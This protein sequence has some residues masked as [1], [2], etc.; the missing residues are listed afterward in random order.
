MYSFKELKNQIEITETTVECPVKNC[1]TKVERQKKEFKRDER[2]LCIKHSIYISPSTYEYVNYQDNLL[3]KD[4]DDIQLLESILKSKRESRISRERS[5][6]ALTWNVFRYLDK[7]NELVEWCSGF[8]KK[9]V[10]YTNIIYWSYC[11]NTNGTYPLLKE[12]RAE[13]GEANSRGSEPDLIIETDKA[14]FF[15]ESKLMAS[16]KTNPS[17]P[18][19]TKKYLTGGSEWFSKVFKSPYS[20]IICN[21]KYELMRFWLLGTW[22]ASKT[23]KE[24]FLVNLVPIFMEEE[25]EANFGKHIIQ[26]E[27]RKFYRLTWENMFSYID[28]KYRTDDEKL[29]S[30]Y[31]LNKTIGYNSNGKLSRALFNQSFTDKKIVIPDTST[32]EEEEELGRLVKELLKK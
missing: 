13:F 27:Q 29:L 28:L 32:P 1:D 9:R 12:A 26:N 5:E 6:D 16:N 3:W 21:S 30:D 19:V 11:K 20:E 8:V 15:I 17:N 24:F 10:S 7:K 25:I 31:L 23:K 2:F 22:M 4:Y 14:L 18:N